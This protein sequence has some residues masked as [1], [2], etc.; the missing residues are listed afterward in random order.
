MQTNSNIN[1][2]RSRTN[3]VMGSTLDLPHAT[4]TNATSSLNNYNAMSAKPP[5]HHSSA[6]QL[7]PHQ[8]RRNRYARLGNQDRSIDTTLSQQSYTSAR[9]LPYTSSRNNSLSDVGLPHRYYAKN[10]GIKRGIRRSAESADHSDDST[11]R[12][13]PQNKPRKTKSALDLH[14]Q[15]LPHPTHKSIQKV[16]LKL[17]NPNQSA[18]TASML[19]VVITPCSSPPDHPVNFFNDSLI[20]DSPPKDFL[21]AEKS[22]VARFQDAEP[23]REVEDPAERK[24]D[25]EDSVSSNGVRATQ[26]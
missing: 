19:N 7:Q 13:V 2:S 10:P 1:Y 17:G 24:E 3:L 21:L 5:P 18:L 15:T 8:Y 6:L 12:L 23:K 16:N 9:L 4:T 14:L 11:R 26:V 25:E 20:G 22:E